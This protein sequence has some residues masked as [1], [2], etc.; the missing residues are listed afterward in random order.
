MNALYKTKYLLK[1][2]YICWIKYPDE[3]EICTKNKIFKTLKNKTANQNLKGQP[4]REN[5]SDKKHAEDLACKAQ[6]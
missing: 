1:D 6:V 5:Q 2:K 3:H 4:T